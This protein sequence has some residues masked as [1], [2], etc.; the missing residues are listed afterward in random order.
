MEMLSQPNQYNTPCRVVYFDENNIRNPAGNFGD[1]QQAYL[2][3]KS[4]AGDSPWA[5][6]PWNEVI[7][8]LLEYHIC[9]GSGVDVST[10]DNLVYAIYYE[11][12]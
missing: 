11:C 3:V 5:L 4:V 10:C 2:F 12:D 1:L 6:M 9:D 7:E 8:K